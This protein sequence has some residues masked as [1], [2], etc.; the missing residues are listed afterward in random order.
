M[1][2]YIELYT[3]NCKLHCDE[4][5]LEL[6]VAMWMNL[7]NRVLREK[8]KMPQKRTFTTTDVKMQN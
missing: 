1:D 3:Q 5:K 8:K 4:N 6:H 7:T 2:K